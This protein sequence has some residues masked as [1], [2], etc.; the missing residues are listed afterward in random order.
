VAAATVFN[1]VRLI[2]YSQTDTE[3][4]SQAARDEALSQPQRAPGPGGRHG[5]QA[6][7][8]DAARAAPVGAEELPNLELSHDAEVCPREIREGAFIVTVDA[9]RGKAAHGTVPQSLSRGDAQGELGCQLVQMPRLQVSGGP[10]REQAGQ[11]FHRP[12]GRKKT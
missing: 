1:V 8:E 3:L 5:R 9:A 6:F 4:A 10:L 12:P 2:R 7:G 11:E